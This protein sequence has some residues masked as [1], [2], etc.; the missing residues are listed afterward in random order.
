M[1]YGK[2][3]KKGREKY[4]MVDFSSVSDSLGESCEGHW[5]PDGVVIRRNYP[6]FGNGK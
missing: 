1:C 5:S 4:I 3:E 2:R 6:D